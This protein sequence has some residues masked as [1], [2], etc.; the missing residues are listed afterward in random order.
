ME[1]NY[2]SRFF[3]ASVSPTHWLIHLRKVEYN[4]LRTVSAFQMQSDPTHAILLL[5]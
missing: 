5:V 2:P 4:L 1:E 3:L